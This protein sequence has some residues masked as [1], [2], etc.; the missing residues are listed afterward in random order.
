VN[1]NALWIVDLILIL[2]CE[3]L[4]SRSLSQHEFSSSFAQGCKANSH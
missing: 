2:S 4:T 1:E 3:S